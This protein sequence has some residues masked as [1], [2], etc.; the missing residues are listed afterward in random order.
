MNNLSTDPANNAFHYFVA[1]VTGLLA[2]ALVLAL[3]YGLFYGEISEF[4]K[5]GGLGS[6]FRDLDPSAFWVSV[7]SHT[8]AICVCIALA[9]SYLKQCPSM[10]RD[11]RTALAIDMQENPKRYE[12]LLAPKKLLQIPIWAAALFGFLLLVI[13]AVLKFQAG[14]LL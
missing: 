3:G 6:V 2:F 1:V 7:L 9:S 11:E 10:S 8:I 14:F 13:F 5:G 12:R 4:R